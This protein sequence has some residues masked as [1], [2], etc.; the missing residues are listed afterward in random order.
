MT[1]KQ[2]SKQNQV[3]VRVRGQTISLVLPKV[4]CGKTKVFSLGLSNT[5]DNLN[6]AELKARQ[7]E[8]DRLTGCF[9]E[10]LEKYK[11]QALLTPQPTPQESLNLPEIYRKYI[12]SRKPFVSPTTWK[13]TY[14]NTLNHLLACP[15][16]FVCEALKVKNWL[17]SNRTVDT[18][19]R[20]LVQ[21]NAACDWACDWELLE[22]NPL[23]GKTKIKFSK[24]SK[25]QIHPFS[26]AEKDLILSSF[27]NS[28]EFSDLLS[29]IKFFFL[30]GC[31]TGEALGLRWKSVKSDFSEISFEESIVIGQGGSVRKR[32]TKQSEMRTFPCNNQLKALLTSLKPKNVS[33]EQSVFVRSNGLPVTRQYLR[34]GWYGKGKSLGIVRQLAADKKIEAYRP[35]YNTRHTWISSCLEKGISATQVALWAGN[36]PEVVFRNYAGVVNKIAVPE[37]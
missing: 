29:I 7:I 13:G 20:V 22:K 35:Q 4:Y 1:R 28:S 15:Y 16:Q 32:G 26:S 25:P 36:S 11:F 6:F 18:A 8:V 9:D 21:L 14:T 17:L 12:E 10:T 23:K 3:K 34:D 33:D 31:R 2:A 5:P 24:K 30:T 19:K 37:L 27:E